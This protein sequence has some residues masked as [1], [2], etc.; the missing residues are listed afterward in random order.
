M[1][2][3][4]LGFVFEHGQELLDG[5]WIT[6]KLLV[7]S[8]LG[9]FALALPLAVGRVSPNRT[10][11]AL[12]RGYSALFRG[13]PLLVQI[14]I[15]YYGF[16]QF[17]AVRNSPAWFVLADAFNCALLALTLNIAAY[18]AED[19]R[20]GIIG[21]PHGEKEAALAYGMGRFGSY[22]HIILPRAIGI[23]APA[24]GNE[25]VSQ[26]KASALA[27]VITVLEMTGVA[28]R[29]SAQSYSTDPLIVAGL[30][31]VAVTLLLSVLVRLAERRINCHQP[32]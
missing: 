14:F 25:V 8:S 20:A 17:E 5:L 15:L 9:G 11:A 31:Y 12:A 24:L 26:L 10:L 16:S 18:M 1:L 2:Y 30:L 28:R 22:V 7:L 19:L 23:A 13:T 21:V 4:Y 32:R 27:S 3:D 6:L 29:F